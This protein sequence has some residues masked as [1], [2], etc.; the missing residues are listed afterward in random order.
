MFYTFNMNFMIYWRSNNMNFIIKFRKNNC[1]YLTCFMYIV[2]LNC[3]I[4]QR[5]YISICSCYNCSQ[6]IFGQ[7]YSKKKKITWNEYLRENH[8]YQIS[9]KNFRKIRKNNVMIDVFDLYGLV[10]SMYYKVVIG[11]S[12]EE[13]FYLLRLI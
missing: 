10:S 13:Y 6:H 8:A 2:I 7:K 3:L 4:K 12:W 9:Y 1:A 11:L 5:H